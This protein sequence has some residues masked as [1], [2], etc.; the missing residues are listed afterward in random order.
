MEKTTYYITNSARQSFNELSVLIGDFEDNFPKAINLDNENYS[1][2]NKSVFDLIQMFGR[3]NLNEP[4]IEITQEELLREG[5]EID[6]IKMLED[7]NYLEV[8]EIPNELEE[9]RAI[10]FQK[11]LLPM[12]YKKEGLLEKLTQLC[13]AYLKGEYPDIPFDIAS[14]IHSIVSN[15][16][17]F[18]NIEALEEWLIPTKED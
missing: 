15:K 10:V 1:N 13:N 3:N 9:L 12:L 5:W 18:E 8:V 4:P 16:T 11:G 6:Q 17:L 2:I 7:E 14:I